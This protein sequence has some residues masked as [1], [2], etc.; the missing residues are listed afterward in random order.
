M[1]Q[2]FEGLHCTMELSRP[3]PGI[4][5]LTIEGSDVGELGDEPFRALEAELAAARPLALFID[6]RDTRGASMN[7]SGD[8]ALWLRRHRDHLAQVTMLT[9]SR[10]LQITADFVRRFSALEDLM[11]ITT[12]PAAFDEAVAD[13]AHAAS[14]HGGSKK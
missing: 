13:A 7:V 12:D 14:A 5:V 4:V 6:G 2:R 1:T 8:W 3:A 9:G 10:F 11:R